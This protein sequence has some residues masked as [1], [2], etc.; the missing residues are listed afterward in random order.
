MEGNVLLLGAVSRNLAC[1]CK[2]EPADCKL[3]L[4]ATH[5]WPGTGL[6][7]RKSEGALTSQIFTTLSS[8]ADITQLPLAVKATALTWPPCLKRFRR[9]AVTAFQ[10]PEAPLELV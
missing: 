1:S 7:G 2:R 5:Y 9:T 3:P 6:G 8:P 4:A 10:I